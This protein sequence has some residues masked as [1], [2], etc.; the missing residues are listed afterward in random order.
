MKLYVV[1]SWKHHTLLGNSGNLRGKSATSQVWAKRNGSMQTCHDFFFFFFF[2]N[3]KINA[4]PPSFS[5]SCFFWVRHD[6]PVGAQGPIGSAD[7][8]RGSGI[9]KH[10]RF[11]PDA[12]PKLACLSWG[13]KKEMPAEEKRGGK[14]EKGRMRQSQPRSNLQFMINLPPASGSHIVPSPR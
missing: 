14:E 9:W 6:G 10:C 7:A 13:S 12:Q 5:T 3:P 1:R 8:S 2:G 4:L 11:G